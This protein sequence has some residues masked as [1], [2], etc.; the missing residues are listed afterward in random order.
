MPRTSCLHSMSLFSCWT[1]IS[2]WSL[3][4]RAFYET[5]RLGHEATVGIPLWD[6]D[7]HAWDIERLR[8]LLER[9][10]PE[11]RPFHGFEVVH[12]FKTVGHKVMILNASRVRAPGD[13]TNLILLSIQDATERRRRRGTPAQFGG[14]LPPVVRISQ[15]WHPDR[16]CRNRKDHR[17]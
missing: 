5:F 17:R 8:E 11:D 7:E 13:S 9:V 2:W 12:D 14:A 3:R 4:N 10:L 16:E 1:R 15:R 6:V